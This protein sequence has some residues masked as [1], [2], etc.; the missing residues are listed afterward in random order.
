MK[1]NRKKQQGATFITWLVVAGFMILVAS[2]VV[3]VAP[4]YIEFNSVKSM[5]K[6]IAGESGIKTA[7]KHQI[8]SKVAKYLNVNN[9]RGLEKVF[10]ASKSRDGKTEN[11]F[12]IVRLKKGDNRKKLTVNYPVETPWISNLSFLIKFEHAVVL[13]EP[14]NISGR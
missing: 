10:Y 13:G 14:D 9:L 6:D 8:N 7:N 3:K 12:S 11:P 1:T 5:M 2:A 4:Y